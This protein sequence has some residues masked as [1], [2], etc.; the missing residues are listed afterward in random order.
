MKVTSKG[1]ITIPQEIR[2]KYLILPNTEVEFKEKDGRIY[3][4]K[5]KSLNTKSSP[6]EKVRGAATSGLSTEDIMKLTRG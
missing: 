3:I 1:Q 2:E 4:E 5:I 6:F